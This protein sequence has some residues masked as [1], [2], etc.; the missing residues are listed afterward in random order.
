[1]TTLRIS[2][3]PSELDVDLIHRYLA[4]ETYWAQGLSRP[5]LERALRHSLCIGGYLAHTQVAFARVV[6]DY[7]T[8]AHLKDVFVLPEH[9]GRGFGL[10]I[11]QYIMGQPELAQVGF[12]LATRDAHRLYQ[13]FGFVVNPNPERAM[14]RPGT[15][16]DAPD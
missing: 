10:A 8:F 12:T 3:D 9:R 5:L 7:A 14:I 2:T 11:M 13:K 15:F 16:L 1:M 4:R 6:T